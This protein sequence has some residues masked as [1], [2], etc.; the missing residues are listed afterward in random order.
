MMNNRF[1]EKIYT[2][3]SINRIKKKTTLLGIYNKIDPIDFMNARLIISLLIFF[4]T[5]LISSYA[6][7]LS[8]VLTIAFYIGVEY[9]VL[10]MRIKKRSSKLDYEALFFFEVLTL[11]LETGRNLKGALDLTV[12]NIDSE[13]SAEFASMLETIDYGKTLTEALND[14]KK[15]IPSD[16]IN[17]VILNITHSNVFGNEVVE[18][19]YNLVDYLR[20]KKLFEAKAQIAK[21][22]I[23]ISVV[24]VVFFI[25]IIL[26]LILTP[27]L[28][29]LI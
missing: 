7:I 27:V 26:L 4:I 20:D 14:M 24:S 11:S 5:F 25:P 2:K 18:T 9:I 23:K 17:N 19:L 28:L 10:D 12:R 29:E 6:Y 13:L 22:P 15:R 3:K 21:M 1:I 8:P 16:T